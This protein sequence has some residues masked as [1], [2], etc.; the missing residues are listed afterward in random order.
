MALLGM[1]TAG[2]FALVVVAGAL[3]QWVLDACR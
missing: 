2:L 3:P 1:L